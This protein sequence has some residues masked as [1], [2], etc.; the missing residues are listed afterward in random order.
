MMGECLVGEWIVGVINF[1]FWV[2]WSKMSYRGE[3][4]GCDA[5]GWTTKM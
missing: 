1:H 4:V 2:V 3:K 5:C